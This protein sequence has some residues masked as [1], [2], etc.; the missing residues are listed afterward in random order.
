MNI[1]QKEY[2]IPSQNQ[3][4]PVIKAIINSDMQVLENIINKNLSNWYI[5]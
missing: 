4:N 5:N 2:S 3:I 1:I